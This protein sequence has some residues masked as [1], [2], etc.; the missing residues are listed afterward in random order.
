M[1]PV[2]EQAFE[3]IQDNPGIGSGVLA[4]KLGIPPC[5]ARRAGKALITEGRA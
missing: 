1:L 4:K 3:I 5:N 2:I